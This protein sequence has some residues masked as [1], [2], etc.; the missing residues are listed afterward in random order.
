[1]GSLLSQWE[2]EQKSRWSRWYGGRGHTLVRYVRIVLVMGFGFAAGIHFA[3]MPAREANSPTAREL[4]AR[5]SEAQDALTAREGELALS[6]MELNRLTTVMQESSRFGIPADLAE[7]IYDTAIQEGIAPQVAFRLVRVES[8]FHKFAVSSRGAVGL[9]QVMPRTARGLDPSVHYPELFERDTNLRLGFRYLH[10]M[11]TKYDGDW[12]L[13]LLAYNRGPGTVD[14][15][16][17]GGGDPANG[18]AR[19][20]LHGVRL[21][22]SPR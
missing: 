6:R 16:R 1:M 21:R 10:A 7:D 2:A 22:P 18:Y 17:S 8:R 11:L 5:L 3:A 12:E 14:S 9:T 15:I 4:S 13:A 19:A 20:V